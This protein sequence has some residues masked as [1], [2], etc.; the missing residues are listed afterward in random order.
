MTHLTGFPCS[1]V[2][3]GSRHGAGAKSG[4]QRNQRSRETGLR[5][6]FAARRM[7]C[8]PYPMRAHR[9]SSRACPGGP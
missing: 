3:R 1:L 2:R 8:G 5:W 4:P 7:R 9:A 6:G